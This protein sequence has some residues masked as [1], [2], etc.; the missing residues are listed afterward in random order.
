MGILRQRYT[1][2]EL[3]G[4]LACTAGIIDRPEP[5]KACDLVKEFSWDKV[6]TQDREPIIQL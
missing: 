6:G 1:P 3:T 4:L 5:V 2:E